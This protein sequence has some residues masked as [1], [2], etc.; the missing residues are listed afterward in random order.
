MDRDMADTTTPGLIELDITSSIWESFFTVFPLVVIGTREADGSDDLAPK[1]L[2]IPM[3]WE[4]HFGFVCTPRH[5][6]YQNI[7][8]DEQFTVT[9]MRPSQTV[10]AS[11]AATPRCEDGSKPI[12]QALPTFEAK[13]VNASFIQDGYLFLECVLHQFVDNLGENSL[14][15]GRI[16]SARVAEDALRASD[17]DDEDLVYASPLLAYLYPGRFA[18]IANTTKLPFPAGFKR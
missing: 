16:I 13:Q 17:E 11:L 15:I 6:T 9:Y 3:S 14:I 5:N 10:L 7:L 4:N 12:T 18:E 2:A 8:R 1:H